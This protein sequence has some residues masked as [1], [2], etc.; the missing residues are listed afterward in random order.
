MS[1]FDQSSDQIFGK[2]IDFENIK[3]NRTN[4]N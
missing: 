4:A 1:E 3:W 2:K